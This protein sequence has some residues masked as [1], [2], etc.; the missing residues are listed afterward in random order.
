M[1]DA[2]KMA[3]F[4]CLVRRGEPPEVDESGGLLI[5]LPEEKIDWGLLEE[6]KENGLVEEKGGCAVL[7]ESGERWLEL[8]DKLD[9]LMLAASEAGVV[10]SPEWGAVV[11]EGK[12]A[13]YFIETGGVLVLTA[14]GE[15]QIAGHERHAEGS[16]LMT[17]ITPAARRKLKEMSK[18][19]GKTMTD[20][21]DELIANA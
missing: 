8:R 11:E 12:R 15:A 19:R 2:S 16:Y 10:T 21:L 3:Q 1:K 5:R 6:A 13:G 4:L 17:K 7:S 20:V 14:T 9:M 18:S